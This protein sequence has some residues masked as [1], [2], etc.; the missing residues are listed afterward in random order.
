MKKIKMGTKSTCKVCGHEIEYVGPYWRHT[1]DWQP[2]HI[3]AP[4][5]HQPQ[6][7]KAVQPTKTARGSLL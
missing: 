2:R 3:A 4:Q 5:E 1:G 6:H 7:N